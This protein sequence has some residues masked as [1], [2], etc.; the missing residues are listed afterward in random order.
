MRFLVKRNARGPLPF[1]VVLSLAFAV[2]GSLS[3]ALHAVRAGRG[4]QHPGRSMGQIDPRDTGD[5][6][7][8][9]G[10]PPAHAGTSAADVA[11]AERDRWQGDPLPAGPP[12]R[13]EPERRPRFESFSRSIAPIV[14]FRGH[15]TDSK[16]FRHE[17]DTVARD[18][19][20]YFSIAAR[21]R[22]DVQSLGSVSTVEDAS[23]GAVAT[24][25]V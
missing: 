24:G 1:R 6:E 13:P 8:A 23:D 2:T 21:A 14:E 5:V 10:T 9:G 3:S 16:R 11:P 22:G 4:R 18:V 12:S 15:D 25:G 17:P 19:R 20:G 7:P